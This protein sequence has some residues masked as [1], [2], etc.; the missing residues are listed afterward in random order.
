MKRLLALVVFVFSVN[1]G[2]V[3]AAGSPP[4]DV[5]FSMD[6]PAGAGCDFNVNWTVTG[7]SS[8]ITL[9]GGGLIGTGPNL[10][11]VVTNLDEPS[12]SVTLNI[13]GAG[14][15]SFGPQGEVMVTVTGRNLLGDPV[16]NIMVLAIGTFHFTADPTN[17]L[18]GLSG[19]G[20]LIDVCAMID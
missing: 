17:A 7:R 15:V 2:M 10:R 14:H 1:A 9:P 8:M 18:V 3:Q 6:I 11:V 16:A 13:Q 5:S 20:Q 4:A 12:E 19:N